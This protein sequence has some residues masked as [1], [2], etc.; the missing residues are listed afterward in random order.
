MVVRGHIQRSTLTGYILTERSRTQR[1][2][3]R[4]KYPGTLTC[5]ETD[6]LPRVAAVG[7][8]GEGRA[9]GG[10]Y[11]FL[12]LPPSRSHL[13]LLAGHLLVSGNISLVRSWGGR[14]NGHRT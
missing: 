11:L 14:Q 1:D 4:R 7:W 2:E 9:G 3:P 10:L 12:L 6:Q 8:E 5:A 13:L